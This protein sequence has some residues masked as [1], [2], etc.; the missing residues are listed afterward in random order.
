M[1]YFLGLDGGATKTEVTIINGEEKKISGAIG[2]PANYHQGGE[3]ETEKNLEETIKDAL[4]QAG[5][6]TKDIKYSVLGLAGFDAESDRK[7]LNELANKL[8][9]GE[10]INRVKVVS[11][12][13]IAFASCI[14]KDFGITIISGT[15]ANC[16]G[17]GKNG[18]VWWSGD[19][20]WLLGDQASGFALGLGA[21]KRIIRE[22]D[23]RGEKTVLTSLILE[24]LSLN[25]PTDLIKWTYGKEIP[26]KEIAGLSPL[27]FKAYKADDKVAQALV[28]KTIIEMVISIET[29][30]KKVNLVNEEFEIGIVGGVFNEKIAVELL[31]TRVGQSLPKAKLVLPK[32]RPAMAAAL[33]AKMLI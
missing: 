8:I 21:L 2:G 16:F 33:M 15:G 10:L 29:V 30:A 19:G 12:V 22:N 3:R 1:K 5:L 14:D 17:K 23:G 18:E 4:S 24:E 6:S 9:D 31:K 32:M 20:G 27:V 28:G 11:D 13:E 25:Q 26:I 7:I